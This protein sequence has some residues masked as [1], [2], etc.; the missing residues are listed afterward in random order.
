MKNISQIAS[1]PFSLSLS[2]SPSK[3]Q[4]I[5]QY[6]LFPTYKLQSLHYSLFRNKDNSFDLN[7]KADTHIN[8]QHC[9]LCTSTVLLLERER[10]DTNLENVPYK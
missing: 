7:S 10:A 8:S 6:V 1:R 2:L 5:K 3:G 9:T 4:L